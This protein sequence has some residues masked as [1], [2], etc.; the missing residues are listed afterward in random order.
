LNIETSVDA[1]Q[2]RKIVP[3]NDDEKLILEN[4][5]RDNPLHIDQLSKNIE[6]NINSLSSLL[7]LMEIKGKVKNI[8]GMRYI[9]AN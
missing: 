2:I 5:D 8:G 3:D 1:E 6:M 4:L 9:I 7:T